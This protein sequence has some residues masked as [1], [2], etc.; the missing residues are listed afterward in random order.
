M[1]W[2]V[3]LVVVLVGLRPRLFAALVLSVWVM[4]DLLTQMRTR[5]K[6]RKSK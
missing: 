2:V 4:A 1:K 6:A 3:L 5:A